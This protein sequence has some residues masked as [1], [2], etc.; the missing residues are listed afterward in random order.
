M[1]SCCNH[2]D[3]SHMVGNIYSDCLHS[4]LNLMSLTSF[5][6]PETQAQELLSRHFP[7][8]TSKLICICICMQYQERQDTI[9]QLDSCIDCSDDERRGYRRA[10]GSWFVV[11]LVLAMMNWAVEDNGAIRPLAPRN[12]PRQ[13]I[14]YQ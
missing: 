6:C 2:S 14:G 12:A 11:V 5:S 4:T 3:A 9:F 13:V 10:R 1:M 8:L 7:W